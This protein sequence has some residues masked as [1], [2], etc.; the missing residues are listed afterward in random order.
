[1]RGGA[2]P[3]LKKVK[4]RRL[5]SPRLFVCNLLYAVRG[6]ILNFQFACSRRRPLTFADCGKSKQKH[7]YAVGPKDETNHRFGLRRLIYTLPFL[8]TFAVGLR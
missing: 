4:A 6:F 7:A 3:Q 2:L 8:L 5:V 1:M